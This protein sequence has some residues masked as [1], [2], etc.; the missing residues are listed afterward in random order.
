MI[1]I[2]VSFFLKSSAVNNF[3]LYAEKTQVISIDEV[4]SIV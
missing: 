1:F 2:N 3:F 4:S